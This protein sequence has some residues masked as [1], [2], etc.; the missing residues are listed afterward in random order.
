MLAQARCL[1]IEKKGSTTIK[2]NNWIHIPSFYI[3]LLSQIHNFFTNT[4]SILSNLLTVSDT[5]STLVV[6]NV[7]A[8]L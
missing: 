7:A 3:S 5:P 4:P 6:L 1:D 8:F 2:E